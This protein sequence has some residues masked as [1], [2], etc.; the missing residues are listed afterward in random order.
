MRKVDH[1]INIKVKIYLQIKASN[2]VENSA[3][4]CLHTEFIT[5]QDLE[6][7]LSTSPLFSILVFQILELLLKRT[8][9]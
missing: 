3:N 8:L 1:S 2:I 9:L 6:K 4:I 5:K 7:I